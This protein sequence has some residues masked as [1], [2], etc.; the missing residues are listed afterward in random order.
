MFFKRFLENATQLRNRVCQ[1]ILDLICL[2]VPVKRHDQMRIC[3]SL[4]R[5]SFSPPHEEA[6]R[7]LHVEQLLAAVAFTHVKAT[8]KETI[9]H[10]RLHL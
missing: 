1:K 6:V 5:S 3:N 10:D 8:L 7:L 2:S 4:F 9:L